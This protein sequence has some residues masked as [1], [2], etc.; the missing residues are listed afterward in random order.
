VD[1]LTAGSSAI[2]KRS[3]AAAARPGH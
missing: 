2:R 3:T 1:H